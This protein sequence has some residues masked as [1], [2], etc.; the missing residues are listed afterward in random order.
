VDIPKELPDAPER[1][2][3]IVVADDSGEMRRSLCDFLGSLPSVEIAGVAAD[4]SEAADVCAAARPDLALIDFAMP[5]LNGLEAARAL[6]RRCPGC[7][8]VVVSNFAPYL[9][10]SDPRPDV[11]AIV[12]KID[13]PREL[14]AVI[15][16]LFPGRFLAPNS[17]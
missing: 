1:R 11:D 13:L 10:A 7:R 17:L 14:P 15:E 6:R 2:I 16:R 12:D 8:V 4:G 9:A 5:H 3:R